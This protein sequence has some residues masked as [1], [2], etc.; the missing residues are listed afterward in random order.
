MKHLAGVVFV[1]CC[2]SVA[3]LILGGTVMNRTH[4]Q[5]V[6][7]RQ[8]VADLWGRPQVQEAPQLS[9]AE[10]TKEREEVEIAGV[11]ETRV[12][13][14]TC[15][16]PLPLSSS[17]IQVKLALSHRKKGLIWYP[18]YRVHFDGSYG[19]ENTLD[20]AATYR[21]RFIF[22]SERGLYDGFVIQ[23]NGEPTS[24]SAPAEGLVDTYVTLAPG[25][26][27][28]ITVAYHSQ[29][30]DA[31]SYLPGE[32]VRE[33]RDFQ[34]NVNTDFAAID[35]PDAAVSPTGKEQNGDGWRL[36]WA[37]DNLISGVK[38]GLSMPERVNP[39][40]FVGRVTFFAPVSLFLFFFLLFMIAV[41]RRIPLHPV[42][43]FF[44]ACAFFSFHLLLAYLVDHI[45][46]GV[47]FA[48]CSVV[49]LFLS[50]SYMRLVVGAGFAFREIGI[51][52]AVY[53]VMFSGA[54]FLEGFAGLSI[55]ICC[56]ITLFVIMQVTGDI[57]WKTAGSRV[58]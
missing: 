6:R 5:D 1:F 21:F 52:Q 15:Y 35:F 9:R 20:Q 36:T 41:I 7:L 57:D 33:I 25:Q 50:I 27:G 14:R 48:I 13:E 34:L 43:Y 58:G 38:I 22:P 4:R 49:S 53:L 31:W 11:V 19:I 46:V 44:L 12:K 28:T 23:V 39:G 32:H 17:K 8:Q 26:R 40:P 10:L 16:R 2:A 37:Y 55:A 42:H 47:A 51:A 56:V 29:G 3:W 45:P 18:T 30:M 24:D 54:F